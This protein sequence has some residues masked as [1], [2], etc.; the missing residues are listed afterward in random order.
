MKKINLYQL[1]TEKQLLT[2]F[3]LN[4]IILT[5][6][7][8]E[9]NGLYGDFLVIEGYKFKHTYGKFQ[10]LETPTEK[11]QKSKVM[12]TKAPNDIYNK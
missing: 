2:K 1:F 12:F 5:E 6:I 9:P 11:I 10:C 8:D 7:L 3:K 4:K